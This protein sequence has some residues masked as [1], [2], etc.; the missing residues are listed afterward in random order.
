MGEER[1]NSFSVARDVSPGTD[2]AP[3][4]GPF[5]WGLIFGVIIALVAAARRLS[6]SSGGEAAP[7]SPAAIEGR[8]P[9]SPPAVETRVLAVRDGESKSLPSTIKAPGIDVVFGQGAMVQK[10]SPPRPATPAQSAQPV[11]PSRSAPARWQEPTKYIVGV[12]MFLALLF[13]LYL[14]RSVIPTVIVAALLALIVH[15]VIGFLQRRLKMR[16]GLSIAVTYLLIVGLLILIP[17]L[18]I[19]SIIN[20][21][22][23]L[24]NL[25][26]QGW[27]ESAAEFVRDLSDRVAGIPVLNSLLGPLLDSVSG[28]FQGISTV[29]APAP[30]SYDVAMSGLVD[31]LA[32]TLGIVASVVGPVVSAVIT[33]VFMLLISLHLSLSGQNMLETFPHL[34]PH[35]YADEI[36]A[37]AQRIGGVW[38][39]F[40]RG[41][42]ALMVIIGVIVWLGN[43][44][45]GN[46]YPLLLGVISGTLEIIP[47]LGPALALI[48]GVGFAL[49]FGSSHFAME[50]LTFALIVLAFYLLVQVFENQLIVPYVLGG[51]LDVPPLAV[52]LGV[53]VGG[54]VGGILGVLLATPFIASGREVFR[55]LYDKILE[56]PEE[57]EPEE[58]QPSFLDSIG[59]RIRSL[60]VPFRRRS[61]QPPASEAAAE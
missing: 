61:G 40:L 21:V 22:N 26:F 14:S 20:A 11:E 19:P 47:N 7:Q 24:I 54:T 59:R 9:A 55:Y 10:T 32:R 1:R 31:R 44:I 15:P 3:W 41:Q 57:P 29:P 17:V 16:R 37:L 25:D 48:P 45:L 23:D 2:S 50:P 39:S 18:L 42:F 60:K 38:L 4:S 12:L 13:L 28:A 27:A 36:T 30:V 53:M 52:I 43:A 46:R 49:I 8:S 34:L 51:E 33:V 56:V 5:V 6:R 58:R 35:R